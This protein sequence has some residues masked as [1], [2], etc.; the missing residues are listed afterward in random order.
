MM[1]AGA[2][3]STMTLVD[4]AV[5]RGDEAQ[6]TLAAAGND[7]TTSAIYALKSG[8]FEKAGL[9]VSLTQMSGGGTITA[10]VIGGAIQIGHSSLLDV[11]RAYLRKVPLTLVAPSAMIDATDADAVQVVVR[12]NSSIQSARDLNGKIIAVPGL[13]DYTWLE[14]SVWMDKHGGDSSSI[15][16]VELSPG[17][18]VAAIAE[19]RVDASVLATPA[20]T[21]GLQSGKFRALGNPFAAVVPRY[22]QVGWFAMAD[23]VN[24]NPDVVRRFARVMHDSAAY[25]NSHQPQTVDLIATFAKMDPQVV[26]SMPREKFALNLDASLIQPLI[27]IAYQYKTIPS[28]F[29]AAAMISEYAYQ[30]RL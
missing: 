8:L 14:A 4:V 30:P 26:R 18:T 19:G 2:G 15:Q 6:I 3:A 10:A 5:A 7:S 16:F 11:I 9:N 24:K 27:D 12:K 28:R 13:K 22:M 21:E 23:Y 29:S 1:C 17:A 20:L 25:C